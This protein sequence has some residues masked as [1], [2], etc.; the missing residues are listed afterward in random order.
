[1]NEVN[2]SKSAAAAGLLKALGGLLG[3]L[4]SP[5]QVYLQS[6]TRY[7]AGGA[8]ASTALES[9]E[10]ERQIQARSDAKARRDFA[11]ADRIRACLLQA[12]VELEDRPGGVTQWRRV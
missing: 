5:P 12:G 8:A 1:A 6:P 10:I 3:L 11:E 2:R 7:V 9:D 4:Q